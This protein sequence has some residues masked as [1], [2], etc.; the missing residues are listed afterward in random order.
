MFS[1]FDVLQKMF[2][3]GR[4][5]G[6]W[7]WNFFISD[8]NDDLSASRKRWEIGLQRFL[9]QKRI[10][11]KAK[12]NQQSKNVLAKMIFLLLQKKAKLSMNSFICRQIYFGIWKRLRKT[13]T[14]YVLKST[15]SNRNKFLREIFY[16]TFIF[17]VKAHKLHIFGS[18]EV[19]SH[20]KLSRFLK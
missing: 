1:I 14:K 9:Q 3:W 10:V 18:N 12:S 2:D 16:V 20:V 11:K 7:W 6:W 17:G 19:L 5:W 4:R 8:Q 15:W 13:E